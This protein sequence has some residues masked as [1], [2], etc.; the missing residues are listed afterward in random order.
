MKLIACALIL[1][2]FLI[3]QDVK[4]KVIFFGDSITEAGVKPGGYIL[5]V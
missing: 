5:K 3:S 1:T 4:K 2:A